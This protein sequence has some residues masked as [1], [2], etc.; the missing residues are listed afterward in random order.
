MIEHLT[1]RVAIMYLGRLVEVG[2]T[3]EIFAAPAHPYSRALLDEA[4]RIGRGHRSYTPLTGE[5]PSPLNP[6]PG[7]HFHTRCPHAMPICKAQ[8]PV[9]KNIAPGRTAACHLNDKTN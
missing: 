6:P 3:R 5:I 9:M 2:P 1:D 4:P 8:A 7:C